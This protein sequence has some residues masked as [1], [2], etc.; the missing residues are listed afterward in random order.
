MILPSFSCLK[1]RRISMD[2]SV[3]GSHGSFCP[4]QLALQLAKPKAA[5][6]AGCQGMVSASRTSQHLALI[7]V[8][9]NISGRKA[10]GDCMERHTVLWSLYGQA[11]RSFHTL[12]ND[13]S[14]CSGKKHCVHRKAR[15]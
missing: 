12:T 4:W 5:L 3:I 10:V 8:S 1:Y 9:Q 6:V 15:E 7:P 14:V 13:R 11:G 2:C